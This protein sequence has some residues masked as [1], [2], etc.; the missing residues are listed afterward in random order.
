MAPGERRDRE[1]GSACWMHLFCKDPG[2]Q[3]ICC[4]PLKVRD[5]PTQL[6]QV[7][8]LGDLVFSE[9]ERRN[10]PRITRHVWR[11]VRVALVV[12]VAIPSDAAYGRLAHQLVAY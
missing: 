10:E 2:R 12:V 7:G 3:G 4:A 5:R 1:R 9:P 6:I 11:D 8:R